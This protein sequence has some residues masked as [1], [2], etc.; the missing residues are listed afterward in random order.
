MAPITLSHVCSRWRDIVLSC[1]KLWSAIRIQF[2]N[3]PDHAHDVLRTFMQNS[4]GYPLEICIRAA[5]SIINPHTKLWEDLADQFWRYSEFSLDSGDLD[6]FLEKASAPGFSLAYLV[7]F[8]IHTT[9]DRNVVFLLQPQTGLSQALRRAPKLRTVQLPIVSPGISSLP[10]SQLTSLK[11]GR[12]FLGHFPDFLG[13][14]RVSRNL[15]SLI[16]VSVTISPEGEPLPDIAHS[17]VQLPFLRTLIIDGDVGTLEINHPC[18][19]RLFTSLEIPSLHTF[20]LCYSAPPTRSEALWPPSLLAMLSHSSSS[21]R[22]VTLCVV[23]FYGAQEP[24]SVLFQCTPNLT[25]LDLYFSSLLDDGGPLP[26]LDATDRAI[27]SFLSDLISQSRLVPNLG[28]LLLQFYEFDWQHL[29]HVVDGMIQLARSSRSKVTNTPGVRPLIDLRL[30]RLNNPEIA[31]HQ[32][33]FSPSSDQVEALEAL[34]KDGVGIEVKDVSGYIPDFDEE[35][36]F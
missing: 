32:A 3:I 29:N 7:A 22:R 6:I 23:G 24:L 30:E 31:L 20:Q 5:P 12:L 9:S 2:R 35:D 18:Y 21:L 8:R 26:P 11:V 14:L 28:T 1:P 19:D 10:Y 25:R 36:R 16:I 4:K 27:S 17:P 13:I 15:R 33:G 34:R